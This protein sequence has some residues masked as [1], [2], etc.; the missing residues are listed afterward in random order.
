MGCLSVKETCYDAIAKALPTF[1]LHIVW[2]PAGIINCPCIVLLS[3]VLN[4]SFFLVSLKCPLGC[5]SVKK[6]CYD[7]IG[8]ALPTLLLDIVWRPAGITDCSCIALKVIQ[9][10]WSW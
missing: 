8:K 1:Q 7:V 4:T 3:K 6:T 9:M 5:L 10:S 2:R